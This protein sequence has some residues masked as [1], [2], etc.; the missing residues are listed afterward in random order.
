M[1]ARLASSICLPLSVNS[2]AA[3][4]LGFL[5]TLVAGSGRQRL[6]LALFAADGLIIV[7]WRQ[8]VNTFFDFFLKN[9]STFSQNVAIELLTRTK[10]IAPFARIA[11]H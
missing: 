4:H 7:L 2:P 11:H 10:K 1:G 6:G 5:A 3:K 9:F 8:R